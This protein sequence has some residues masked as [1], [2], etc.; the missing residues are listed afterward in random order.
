LS[1]PDKNH[2]LKY[3]TIKRNKHYALF[4]VDFENTSNVASIAC[5]LFQTGNTNSMVNGIEVFQPY[6]VSSSRSGKVNIVSAYTIENN[7]LRLLYNKK[8]LPLPLS[9]PPPPKILTR[10]SE[11]NFDKYINILLKKMIQIASAYY[12]NSK[13][14]SCC[15]LWPLFFI[16]HFHTQYLP[17]FID[18]AI[19]MILKLKA[20]RVIYLK[21]LCS[22][23]FE[24]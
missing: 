15:Y 9:P 3:R 1:D 18:R 7:L 2:W 20:V 11:K 23:H 14:G 19:I 5:Y 16:T 24:I 4:D 6:N 8:I 12:M 13:V 22:V 10:V 21:C 17:L